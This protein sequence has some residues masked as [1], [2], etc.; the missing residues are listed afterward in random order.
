MR[1]LR[2]VVIVVALLLAACGGSSNDDTVE[3]DDVPASTTGAPSTA[4]PSVTAAP[5]TTAVPTTTSASGSP[6]D[7]AGPAPS[8]GGLA[9]LFRSLEQSADG[10]LDLAEVDPED[11]ACVAGQL[12]PE[13]LD[14]LARDARPTAPA[15]RDLV[16]AVEGCDVDLAELAGIEGVDGAGVACLVAGLSD[17]TLE[18]L[19]ADA[20]P[21]IGQIRE[22]LDAVVTCEI[23][24]E[25]FLDDD[26]AGAL[27][28]IE[29]EQLVC[30][31]D[32]LDDDTLAALSAGE[33]PSAEQLRQV[34]DAIVTCEIEPEAFLDDAA[35]FGDVDLEQVVCLF[36][37][38]GDETLD[39]LLSG[40]EPSNEALLDL[41][42]A[43][44]T[45][46]IDLADLG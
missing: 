3:T 43:L 6:T 33:L 29:P 25:A 5:P 10:E 36:D 16:D 37:T 42:G 1:T 20:E 38:V 9:S 31:F 19:A 17:G 35:G 40:G 21:T 27:G 39:V 2:S 44:D 45:C 4:A 32:A 34:L 30:V 28:A 24:P 23:P 41:L 14:L 26:A 46:D 13:T 22:V 7:D 8:G 12:D 11:A 15:L 18:A